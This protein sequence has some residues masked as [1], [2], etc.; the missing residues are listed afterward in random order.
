MS[1]PLSQ[2]K[3]ALIELLRRVPYFSGFTDAELRSLIDQGYRQVMAPKQIICQEDDLGDSFY[4]VLSGVVEVISAR[5]GMY[6]AT[7]QEGDFF[8]EIALLTGTP[9][10]ATVRTVVDTKLFVLD[11]EHLQNLLLE[12]PDLAEQIAETLS[13]RQHMLISLGVIKEEELVNSQET[14][15][16]LVRQHLNTVF[17]L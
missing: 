11:R 1:V 16:S 7:L 4:I 6:I 14:Y 3:R 10:T 15:L 5:T 12:H 13:E 2:T 9:R 8:G 17:G